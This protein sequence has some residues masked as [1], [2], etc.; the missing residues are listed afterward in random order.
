MTACKDYKLTRRR[1]MTQSAAGAT[2]LGMPISQ[3]MAASGRDHAAKCEHVIL[4][5]NGGGMSHIDTWDPKPGRETQGEFEPIKTS[6]D[7]IQISEIFP[8]VATQMHN[9][10]L[11]RSIAGTQGA[12]ARAT[13]N[14]QTSFLPGPV[15]HPGIGSVVAHEKEKLGDLP[16]FISISGQARTASYLG[17]SCEAYFIANPGDPDPYLKFPAGVAMERGNNRLERLAKFNNRFN[18]DTTD[19]RLTSTIDGDRRSGPL[20]AK[21]GA[22]SL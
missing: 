12:H 5:W 9:A 3:L 14:L 1:M 4:F 19:S 7:G 11:I 20:D 21:P 15:Q 6:A 22:Q 8:K 10:T 13:Y 16:A 2:L 17:Q 18:R